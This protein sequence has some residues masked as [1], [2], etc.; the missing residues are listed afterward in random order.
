MLITYKN[1]I[2]FIMRCFFLRRAQVPGGRSGGSVLLHSHWCIYG[3]YLCWNVPA[4]QPDG[5]DPSTLCNTNRR[6]GDEGCGENLSHRFHHAVIPAHILKKAIDCGQHT[7]RRIAVYEPLLI[8]DHQFLGNL[9][10][11]GKSCKSADV[12]PVFLNGDR[13]F[14]KQ[15]KGIILVKMVPL[16][17]LFCFSRPS[18]TLLFPDSTE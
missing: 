12:P 14:C 5:S 7:G 13:A 17:C 1:H 6:T 11:S 15:N 4:S 8:V 16:L 3:S 9:A 2:T 10:A 18:H